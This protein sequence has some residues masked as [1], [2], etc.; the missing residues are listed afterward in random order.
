MTTNLFRYACSLAACAISLA[1]SSNA[2]AA[3]ANT[4]IYSDVSITFAGETYGFGGTQQSFAQ[5]EDGGRIV[6][7]LTTVGTPDYQALPQIDSSGLNARGNTW[8]VVTRLGH[9]TYTYVGTCAST[10]F[11][12]VESGVS[13]RHLYLDCQTLGTSKTP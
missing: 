8:Q 7:D 5:T 3:K 9:T 10:T 2:L 11:S 6:F 12:T 13:I 1:V 4:A